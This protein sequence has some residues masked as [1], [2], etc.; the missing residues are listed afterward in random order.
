MVDVV[1]PSK[2]SHMM[3]G[4]RSKDTQPELL[5]RKAL[6]ARGYRYRLHAKGLAGKPDLVLPKFKAVV[7]VHGCFWHCHGC[8]LFKWPQTRVEFWQAKILSN[9]VRDAKHRSELIN[10]GWRIAIIWECALKGKNKMDLLCLIDVLEDWL[11][12]DSSELD[13]SG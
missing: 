10:S 9:K 5:V 12:G 11:S 2:R 3:S 8:H 13:I 7:F 1:K 6:F 4:I